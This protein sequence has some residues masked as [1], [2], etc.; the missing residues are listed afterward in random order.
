[1]I[2]KYQYLERE[3]EEFVKVSWR[4]YKGIVSF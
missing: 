1:M 4:K 3:A 2:V